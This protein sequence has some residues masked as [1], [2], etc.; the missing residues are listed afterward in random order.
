M[1]GLVLPTATTYLMPVLLLLSI[2]S[3][4]VVTTSPEAASPVAWWPRPHSC[5]Y[6][7]PAES[8]WRGGHCRR[9]RVR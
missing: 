8:R 3:C 6:R 9:T 1:R 7:S 5:C 2:S 4:C